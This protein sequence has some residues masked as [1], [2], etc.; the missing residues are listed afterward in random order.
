MAKELGADISITVQREDSSQDLAKKV[1]SLLGEQPHVTI[2]CTGVEA[3]A[4]T[5]IY[6]S[7]ARRAEMRPFWPASLF[8]SLLSGLL[9][10]YESIK[11]TF[12]SFILCVVASA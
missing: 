12:S 4:Q 11:S 9:S 8:Q 1:E 2:E 6:V 10:L 3:S 5:A 7:V